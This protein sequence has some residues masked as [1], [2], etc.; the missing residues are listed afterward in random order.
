MAGNGRA[1]RP[2]G[3][4]PALVQLTGPTEDEGNNLISFN[5]AGEQTAESKFASYQTSRRLLYHY[6]FLTFRKQQGQPPPTS[7]CL[8]ASSNKKILN[9]KIHAIKFIFYF[10][11]TALPLV[12]ATMGTSRS[13]DSPHFVP[14][15]LM[16]LI[17]TAELPPKRCSGGG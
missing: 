13:T 6:Y 10:L 12:P 17:D 4:I 7:V 14:Q 11:L 1:G 8:T 2:S 16:N 15:C 3:L 5:S 9:H